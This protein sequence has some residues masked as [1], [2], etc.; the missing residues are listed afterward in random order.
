MCSQSRCGNSGP[1]TGPPESGSGV[2]GIPLISGGRIAEGD[3]P[4]P[5]PGGFRPDPWFGRPFH[6]AKVRVMGF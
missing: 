1:S 5:L 4:P 3:S 2:Y 6:G